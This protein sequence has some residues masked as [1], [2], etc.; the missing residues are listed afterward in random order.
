[1]THDDLATLLREDL[2]ATEPTHT[3]DARVPVGLGRRRLRTRRLVAGATAAAVI[4]IGAAVAVPLVRGDDTAGTRHAIDPASQKALDEYDAQRMPQLMDEHVRS[5]LE[6]SVP[7][8]GPATFRAADGNGD[9]LSPDLYDKAS[10]MS[11]TYGP[12]EHRFSVS[13]SHA[14]S[15]AEGSAQRYC[16][17]GLASGSYLECTVATPGDDVVISK[18]EARRAFKGDGWMLVPTDALATTNPDRLWFFHSEKVIKSE[19]LVTY[20]EEQ[21]KAPSREAA[22]TAFQVPVADLVEIG[23]DPVMVI[24]PPPPA[25]DGC[26]PWILD[27]AHGKQVCDASH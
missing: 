15:E 1:M 3:P 23:T 11:V 17:D 7:D 24:P 14:K 18:L 8:L 4:A 2:A 10:G 13:L 5:V 6:H 27:P 19:T 9:E 26:G 16:K 21:V 22:E 20:V 25:D 12:E